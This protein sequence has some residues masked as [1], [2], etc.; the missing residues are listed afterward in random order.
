[1]QLC[2]NKKGRG[3]RIAKVQSCKGPICL[4]KF[5]IQL[6]SPVIYMIYD[7]PLPK[8]TQAQGPAGME[9]LKEMPQFQKASLGGVISSCSC[10]LGRAS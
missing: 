5:E 6:R 8:E 4:K 9:G 7:F 3:L 2:R 1:M 10:L